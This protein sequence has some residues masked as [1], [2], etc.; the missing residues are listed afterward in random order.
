MKDWIQK[1]LAWID[2]QFLAAPAVVKR[3]EGTVEL[4]SSLKSGKVFYTLDGTDPR[5]PGGNVS[6]NAIPAK[7]AVTCT[8]KTRVFARVEQEHRWS[9]PLILE[10][11]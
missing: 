3:P 1:R 10:R 7:G 9:A 2:D 5:S 8:A 11:P 6:G 4:S